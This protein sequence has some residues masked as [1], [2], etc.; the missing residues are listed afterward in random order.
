M[1]VYESYVKLSL[2]NSNKLNV[3]VITCKQNDLVSNNFEEAGYSNFKLYNTESKSKQEQP[4]LLY[5]TSKLYAVIPNDVSN[6]YKLNF[7]SGIYL[8]DEQGGFTGVADDFVSSNA[9]RGLSYD[10]ANDGVLVRDYSI[11]LNM[12]SNNHSMRNI[13]YFVKYNYSYNYT[14]TSNRKYRPEEELYLYRLPIKEY[15]MDGDTVVLIPDH[16]SIRKKKLFKHNIETPIGAF[17]NI[18]KTNKDTVQ[19]LYTEMFSEKTKEA[20][21]PERSVMENIKMTTIAIAAIGIYLLLEF[22]GIH[23]E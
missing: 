5:T 7:N 3:S 13:I 17:T 21:V 4:D 2:D 19:D 12:V 23:F 18:L 22:N 11:P 16:E 1:D 6:E 10:L 20:V 14:V 9:A 8:I 15:L